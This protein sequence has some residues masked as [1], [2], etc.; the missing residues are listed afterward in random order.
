M[1]SAFH[2]RLHL[3]CTITLC[4]H[5]PK[6]F[7]RTKSLKQSFIPVT[8]KRQNDSTHTHSPVPIDNDIYSLSIV[9]RP[10]TST[11]TNSTIA[12]VG[13]TVKDNFVNAMMTATSPSHSSRVLDG[14]EDSL[15]LIIPSK[16]DYETLARTLEDLLALYK[17][18]EPCAN[19]VF[20]W[21]Q[22]HL[23]DM[24][25]RLGTDRHGVVVKGGVSCADWIDLC[26]R[27]NAP[28][29][30][31]DATL[32]YETYCESAGKTAHGNGLEF[33]DI[34]RLLD[35]LRHWIAERAPEGGNAIKDPRNELFNRVVRMK[36]DLDQSRISSPAE[37]SGVFVKGFGDEPD[38]VETISA[39][40]FLNFLQIEQKETDQ[41][42]ESVKALFARLNGYKDPNLENDIVSTVD[43]VS[44][45]REYISLETFARYMLLESNDVYDPMRTA[46]SPS[47]MSE[48]LN[49]YWIN[50]S[51]DTYL[52][53]TNGQATCQKQMD[54]TDLQ[55]YTLALYRGARAIE[56]DVWDGPAGSK[57]PV[58]RSGVSSFPDETAPSVNKPSN[59][60]RS[61]PGLIF[62][63]VLSTIRYFLQSEPNSYPVILLIEN[64][65]SVR[66][67][68]KMASD[69][70]AIFGESNI[71]YKPSAP[72]VQ[73]LPSPAELLGKVIIK[74][75]RPENIYHDSSVLNDDFDDEN[76]AAVP[77]SHADY[78]SE[79]DI[80]EVVIG[81]K[82]SGTIKS[83]FA[84]KI[85]LKELFQTANSEASD[86]SAAANV[87]HNELMEA[88]AAEQQAR[89]H[90]DALL[91]DI[92]MTYEELKAKRN[93]GKD[94][95]V[96]EGTEVEL[97]QDG[98]RVKESVNHAVE[99]AK[100]FAE[101][102]EES[103]LLS[104]AANAEA[105]S[106]TELFEIA[107][108]DLTEKETILADAKEALQEIIKRNA[109]LSEAAERALADARS[110][111]EYADNARSRVDSV[112]ALLDKSHNQAVSS[113]T[114]AGTADT[115]ARI[116]EQRAVDAE[117]R[118]KKARDS[119]DEERR[120]AEKESKL[121]DDIAAQLASA[122]TK[123]T[124]ARNSVKAA[125]ERADDAVYKADKLTD[126]ISLMKSASRHQ[127]F[128]H[129][130][131]FDDEQSLVD[132]RKICID[133]M[134][135]A[136]SDKLSRE[137]KTRQ[138]ATLVEDLS[139][140]LRLQAKAAAAARRQADH[141]MAVAEQLEEHALEEREAANL[142]S[143]AREKAKLSVKNS[144]AV[145][146]SIEAQLAEAERAA[147][148]ADDLAVLSRKNAER[149][150]QEL[151][152]LQDPSPLKTA[153]EI[154]TIERDSALLIYEI[155]KESKEK[156][157]QRA[158]EAKQLHE[159]DCIR[160]KSM[161]REAMAELLNMESAQQAEVLAISA[162][163]NA[164]VHSERLGSLE[165]KYENAKALA[166]EKNGA[167]EIARRYKEKKIRVQPI[168]PDLANLTFF[169]SCKHKSWEKSIVLPVCS[170]HSIPSDKVIE[171]AEQGKDEWKQWVE[172]NKHHITRTFPQ[173][174]LRN[175]NPML[176]WALGCQC[177]SLNFIRN[178][179]M[180]LNDGRFRENGSQGYVLK[181]EYLCRNSLDESAVDDAMNCKHPRTITVRVL[182]GYCIPK[183]EESG[184]ASYHGT[185]R[186][187]VNP[188]VRVT[189]Y[190][191]SPATF[192]QPPTHSTKVLQGN[193]LNPVWN[194][195]EKSFAC[196]NP[197]VGMLLIAVYDRCDASK[198]D[199]FIGASAI[200]V[201][202]IREGY[203]CVSL[204][205]SQ[206]MRSSAL[207]FA[208][209]LIKVKI[210]V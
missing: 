5:L 81:F 121:E 201:S 89:R 79:D 144:D 74:S 83:P 143:A 193:G 86:S 67:Q 104:N 191:G 2:S 44:W 134:E 210:E 171:R 102:V 108:C 61:G 59:V 94:C 124:D 154:A 60:G 27:W 90:A 77:P 145:M 198:S 184:S 14:G 123:L 101:S 162:C 186:R 1:N 132:E 6:T 103:R 205:D 176:P 138:L 197:S 50:T 113:E 66:Y 3:F 177:V 127:Q 199:L 156:A 99:L 149:L 28:V 117:A 8:P 115:E 126:E 159:K 157:D 45:E 136:F 75:K 35:V 82:S 18:V 182:S 169:H 105:R 120:K 203:R 73:T 63:D 68:K 38:H 13:S 88:K 16:T 179:F 31:T 70:N 129:S 97:C 107:R 64:H 173:S 15:D 187:S 12:S 183:S 128:S 130:G 20:A 51:H 17:E 168:S 71:L 163:E 174:S 192:L 46:H 56:L 69:I 140:K 208:S 55:S 4:I 119:A 166:V 78:D 206:N 65:C 24:G 207:K 137:A 52:R 122:M 164:I 202:C 148:E 76:R 209:L 170:M 47:Y 185:Q 155:A 57:D 194:D 92:G 23:V 106:E 9:Y 161:E 142:R 62:A 25:K 80:N 37:D 72:D 41:T 42:L 58:V 125:K 111:R 43:G 95:H 151:E 175:Y 100:A 189:L 112:R 196:L 165:Q 139:R 188:F 146:Q 40:T 118:A 93:S 36:P 7:I 167:L 204:F 181:P 133:Q 49:N 152:T 10:P 91:R 147:R 135:D 26:R 109:D 160:L 141:G 131:S 11:T 178:Q 200:P 172:F 19:P 34:V 33:I 158:A 29:S 53:R 85:S 180:L 87:A 153:V 114:V 30:K 98:A 110:N 54:W 190:D 195:K 39:A 84:Q 48:P 96:E 21:I 150:A 22:Y 116:S 32:L